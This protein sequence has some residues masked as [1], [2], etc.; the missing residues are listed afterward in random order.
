MSCNCFCCDGLADFLYFEL[1]N[2]TD[3][4]E[5]DEVVGLTPN[6]DTDADRGLVNGVMTDDVGDPDPFLGFLAFVVVAMAAADEKDGELY[7]LS[8]TFR[9]DMAAAA[10]AVAI[11]VVDSVFFSLWAGFGGT[12]M[13]FGLGFTVF[14]VADGI[15]S[16]LKISE[17]ARFGVDGCWT[18]FGARLIP[19]PVK[20][21]SL[22]ESTSSNLI[23]WFKYS[24]IWADSSKEGSLVTKS[25]K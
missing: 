14:L 7:F 10:A 8:G 5:D 17:E 15:S 18:N 6:F 1:V 11:C 16:S 24:S 2:E 4:M 21:E 12:L 20:F 25:S 13:A 3:E 9:E 19:S 23:Y 22:G